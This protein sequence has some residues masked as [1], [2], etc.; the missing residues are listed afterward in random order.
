MSAFGLLGQPP[1]EADVLNRAEMRRVV[2]EREEHDKK[3]A[4][5]KANP[6]VVI[7]VFPRQVAV[8]YQNPDK[9]KGERGHL[10]TDPVH[11]VSFDYRHFPLYITAF[12]EWQ[13][14]DVCV[15]DL[16]PP[17]NYGLGIYVE[18]RDPVEDDDELICRVKRGGDTL[19]ITGKMVSDRPF[20]IY[21]EDRAWHD[22]FEP[23]R[24][25]RTYVEVELDDKP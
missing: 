2:F 18:G 22:K 5:L 4:Y 25:P 6:G 3:M 12:D 23:S 16:E 20:V 13:D 17:L 19:H 9:S 15:V 21:A 10:I 24:P 7:A 11:E 8:Q 1:S 14:D